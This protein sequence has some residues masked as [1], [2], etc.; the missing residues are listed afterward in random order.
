MVVVVLL[1]MLPLLDA[2]DE[3][4]L[5]AVDAEPQQAGDQFELGHFE[6]A[7]ISVL[8]VGDLV[9][10]ERRRATHGVGA[11][12]GSKLE[13]TRARVMVWSPGGGEELL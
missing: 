11:G 3:V 6:P 8:G 1:Q 9:G 4:G 7:A 2:V 13:A 10:A 12:V 5:V